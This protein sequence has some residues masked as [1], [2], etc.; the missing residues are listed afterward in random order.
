LR[1]AGLLF[2]FYG[3]G[4]QIAGK[5]AG[6]LPVWL[7]LGA[8]CVALAFKKLFKIVFFRTWVKAVLAAGIT[9][10]IIFTGVI[11]ANGCKA[12]PKEASDYVIVL[13]GQI[14]GE[15]PSRTLQSRLDAAYDYLINYEE[16]KAILSGGQGENE[17]ISEAEAMRRYL[18]GKGIEENRLVLEDRSS[19][20][21]ENLRNSLALLKNQ[22]NVTIC[23]V[24]SDFHLLRA[25]MLAAKLGVEVDGFGAE[26]DILLIPNYYLREMMAIVKDLALH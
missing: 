8:L 10:V 1:T 22:K 19:N 15:R 3:T 18:I 7:V 2:I 6:M 5:D 12:L 26:G 13:G 17:E 24:T 16:A 11:A 21:Y 25:K 23:I 20:T 9:A 14:E 4:L